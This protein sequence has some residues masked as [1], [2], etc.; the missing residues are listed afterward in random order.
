MDYGILTIDFGKCRWEAGK[1][2]AQREKEGGRWM[3]LNQLNYFVML[4][5]ME[6]YTKAA[7][8]LA[9]TQPSLS[10]A[11]SMLEAEL[12]TPLFEKRGRNVA[13]TKYGR[14]FLEY[15]EEALKTLESGVK[16]TRALTG[17]T[18]GVVE[19]AYIFTLGTEFV[20]EIVSSFM[21]EHE[22]WDIRFQFT[23]GNTTD[24]IQGL[25]DEKYEIAFCS[26][27]EKEP[28][29]E[30]LPVGKEKLVVVV[31]KGHPLSKKD[32]VNL[33][34]TLGYSYVYFTK[35]SGLR[36]TIDQLFEKI[37]GKPKIAYEIMEDGCMAGLVAQNFGIAIMPD[38][39]ILKNLNVDVIDIASPSYERSIY[40]ARPKNRYMTPIAREFMHYVQVNCGEGKR[41]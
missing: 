10:H 9:I 16:K 14:I 21:K 37:G 39:P 30:F 4:A 32:A 36:P 28:N 25:K 7:E 3:N 33:E 18:S 5:H 26:R 38:V 34:D 13:L 24:I 23:V 17:E 35:N 20:P 31:P 1:R 27:K 41:I 2:M 12:Q 19:L 11:I 6:H 15:V 40:M 29:I 22:G 8:K